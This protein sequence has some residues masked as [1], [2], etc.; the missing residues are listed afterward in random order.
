MTDRDR[1]LEIIRELLCHAVSRDETAELELPFIVVCTDRHS[2]RRSYVGPFPDALAALGYVE[3]DCSRP[4][5][6]VANR[7]SIAALHPPGNAV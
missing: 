6:Q 7:Y 5:D 2:G 3:T 4:G 1:R